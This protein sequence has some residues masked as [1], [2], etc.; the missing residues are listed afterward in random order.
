[1]NVNIA[2]QHPLV[3]SRTASCN[4]AQYSVKQLPTTAQLHFA[5][6]A[7]LDQTNAHTINSVKV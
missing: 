5:K 2:R 7:S 3:N 1:V 6:A 4:L